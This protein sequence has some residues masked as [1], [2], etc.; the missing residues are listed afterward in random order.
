MWN[1]NHLYYF[2][3]TALTGK[4]TEAAK[5]LKISQPSL[6]AQLKV[7]EGAFGFNLFFKN[8]RSIELTVEG[9]RI[10]HYA[11]R[12]F[13]VAEDLRAALVQKSENA[14][15]LKRVRV[16]VL[17]E[18]ERPFVVDLLGRFTKT[19]GVNILKFTL[20]SGQHAELLQSLRF[21][22]LD[23]LI[24]N[25]P[26]YLDGIENIA[27]KKMSVHLVGVKHFCANMKKI[28]K[29]KP[30]WKSQPTLNWVMPSYKLKLRKEVDLFLEKQHYT[31]QVVFEGD[32]MTALGRAFID[33]FGVG[34]VP[35][36]YVESLL[37][38]NQLFSLGPS[39]GFWQHSIWLQMR[40]FKIDPVVKKG[41]VSAFLQA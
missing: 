32:V 1:Y 5:R 14:L 31:P 4:V 35:T 11:R 12:M 2:Y 10:F 19:V 25:M 41:L 7:L 23:A 39:T 8:G 27:E 15:S 20:M 34:F 16:G 13:E 28:I 21:G 37:K 18:I 26:T 24:T 6:S 29:G 9:H 17:D 38:K 22:N 3:I 33:G 30:Y 40:D 36:A